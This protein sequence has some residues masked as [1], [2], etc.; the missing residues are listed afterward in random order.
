MALDEPV[1]QLRQS[2]RKA[3]KGGLPAMEL[4]TIPSMW[5]LGQMRGTTS[6]RPLFLPISSL[7]SVIVWK[8]Y[9]RPIT[10]PPVSTILQSPPGSRIPVRFPESLLLF[11]RVL[12]CLRREG[13]TP[14]FLLPPLPF[15]SR[16]GRMES[17]QVNFLHTDLCLPVGSLGA[18]W[19]TLK[20][21]K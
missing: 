8:G 7:P 13:R 20:S 16:Y 19:G 15:S 3:D 17:S 5:P 9:R 4:W 12:L 11:H 21:N 1:L 2:L 10:L 6:K 18:P 14:D